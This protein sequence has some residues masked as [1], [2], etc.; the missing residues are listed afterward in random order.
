MQTKQLVVL[1]GLPGSGKSSLCK[2]PEFESYVRISQD[3][4][5]REGHRNLFNRALHDKRNIIIDRCGFNKEQRQRYIKPAKAAGYVTTIMWLK[6][7]AE[8]CIERI[9]KRADHPNLTKDSSNILDVV[10]MFDNMFVDPT[11]D[12]ADQLMIVKGENHD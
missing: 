4:Q 5:G 8:V 6:V 11:I 9:K 12:E 10:K 7:P 1:V 2:L 3:E